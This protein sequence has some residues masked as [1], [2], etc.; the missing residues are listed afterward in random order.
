MRPTSRIAGLAIV[1][2]AVTCVFAGRAGAQAFSSSCDRFEVD[3]NVFGPADGVPD[4]VDEFDN[5]TIAPDWAQLLGTSVEAGGVV[6]LR[7]PGTPIPLPGFNSVTSNIE[8]ATGLLNGSGN[9]TLTAYWVPVI[10]ATDTQLHLQMCGLG[11]GSEPAGLSCGTLSAAAPAA[12]PGAI[13]GPAVSQ[14]LTYIGSPAPPQQ[15]ATVAVNP[16]DITGRIVFRIS[17]DDAT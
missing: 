9:F 16:A 6:T 10:P 17:F 15:F 5:G 14:Q 7:D 3:G 2:L 13:A 12:Q 1:V 8:N 4:F 11:S